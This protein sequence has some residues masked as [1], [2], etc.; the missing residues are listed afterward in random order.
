MH[1][2]KFRLLQDVII[3]DTNKITFIVSLLPKN[4]KNCYLVADHTGPILQKNLIAL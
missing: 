3:N 2:K 1:K 4:K